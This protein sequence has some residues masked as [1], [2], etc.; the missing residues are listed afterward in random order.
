MD[1]IKIMVLWK[2]KK[3]N[4]FCAYM[5]KKKYNKNHPLNINEI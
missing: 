4:V 3:S 2:I 1:A 5:K